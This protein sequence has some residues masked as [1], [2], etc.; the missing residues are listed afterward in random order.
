MRKECEEMTWSDSCG[1]S[2]DI[3]MISRAVHRNRFGGPKERTRTTG[4]VD[5]T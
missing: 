3:G 2:S 5:L 1:D 4:F